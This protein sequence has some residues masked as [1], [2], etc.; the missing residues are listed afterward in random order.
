ML[1]QLPRLTQL[2]KSQAAWLMPRQQMAMQFRMAV[3]WW[4]PVALE[5]MILALSAQMLASELQL[6]QQRLSWQWLQQGVLQAF[7]ALLRS[8]EGAQV[9]P[10]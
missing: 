7:E 10:C 6:A 1:P 4:L 9:D 2:Y 5:Q 8:L 3:M